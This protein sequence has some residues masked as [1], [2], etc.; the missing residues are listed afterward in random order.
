M[1]YN[2]VCDD[3]QIVVMN[4]V[5]VRKVNALTLDLEKAM[6]VR[7]SLTLFWEANG[8]HLTMRALGISQRRARMLLQS[9]R[10]PL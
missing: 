3:P 2:D 1:N 5:L 4:D 10:P 7:L 6:V 9:K 8:A